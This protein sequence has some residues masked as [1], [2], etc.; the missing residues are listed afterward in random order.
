M[1]YKTGRTPTV[2]AIVVTT[3][4]RFYGH[5]AVVENYK[6]NRF[7]ASAL[8][9]IVETLDFDYLMAWET[10]VLALRPS[11][12]SWFLHQLRDTDFAVGH[13]HHEQF[14]NPSCTLYRADVLRDM[15]AWC[16]IECPQDELRWGPTF[17]LTAPLDNNLANN[18]NPAEI[19][20]NLKQWICGPFAEKRGFPQGTQLRESP[21]GQLKGPGWYEPGQQL[22]AWAVN[23][24][25][26]YTVCHTQTF[27]RQPGMPVQTVYGGN[28]V[29]R[30]L[31]LAELQS[32]GAMTVH[33]WGGT[34]ALDII[35]H[36]VTCQFVASNTPFWLEREAR[37]WRESVPEDVQRDTLE[38]IRKYGWHYRGQGTPTVTDRDRAAAEFVRGRYRQGGV[39]W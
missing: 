5:V 29:D 11:W 12:L 34:R 25:Y 6:G 30:M 38:L 22:H 20:L 33:L 35:K 36:D 27:E 28:Q 23:N 7:H 10:D 26:T 4:N 39:E 16:K 19:L 3:E 13:W 21:S 31:T 8:D 9:C 24:G 2:G 1:G 32:C 17:N 37:L 15:A 14:I 18:E